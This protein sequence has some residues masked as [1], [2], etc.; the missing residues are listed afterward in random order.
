LLETH[1]LS[2]AFERPTMR[3]LALPLTD[4]R[5]S[6]DEAQWSIARANW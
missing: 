2:R 5:R 1:E 4:S 3:V 6:G